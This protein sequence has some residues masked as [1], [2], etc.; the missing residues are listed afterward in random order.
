LFPADALPLSGVCT[1]GLR[2]GE[3][4]ERE[5]DVGLGGMR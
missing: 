3:V 1:V 2:L 5:V 4:V